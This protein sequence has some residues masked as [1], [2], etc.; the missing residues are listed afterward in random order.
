MY[1]TYIFPEEEI[2]MKVNLFNVDL[3]HL[4]ECI[5]SA[6]SAKI[7]QAKLLLKNKDNSDKSGK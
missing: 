6:E 3:G 2:M 5:V 4:S 7:Q 1:L